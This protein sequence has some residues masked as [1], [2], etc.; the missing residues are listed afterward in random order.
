MKHP[1]LVSQVRS[2]VTKSPRMTHTYGWCVDMQIWE[3]GSGVWG[4]VLSTVSSELPANPPPPP[5]PQAMN[6]EASAAAVAVVVAAAAANAAAAAVLCGKPPPPPA[7]AGPLLRCYRCYP[8]A[9][10]W[11]QGSGHCFCQ[12]RRGRGQGRRERS[13][14]ESVNKISNEAPS[15]RPREARVLGPR[16]GWAAAATVA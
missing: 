16:T 11:H 8:P 1:I 12:C 5:G 7:V 14:I 9:P 2:I 10:A 15:P 4:G 6:E 13:A 3:G